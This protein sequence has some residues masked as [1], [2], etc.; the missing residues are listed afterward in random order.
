[1]SIYVNLRDS[2]YDSLNV[3]FPTTQIVQAYNNGPEVV[4]PYVTFDVVD[5]DQI[6]EEYLSSFADEE[7]MQQIVSQYEVKVRI[8]F[9]GKQDSSFDAAAL[10]N[11]F[12]FVIDQTPT[13]HAF[14]L[15][16]LSYLRKDSVKRIPRKRE[17]DWYINYQIDL[18]FGYQVEARQSIDI[19]ESVNIEADYDYES[20]DSFIHTIQIP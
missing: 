12:Y 19:I 11:D 3:I 20:H 4:T 6:G 10:A 15:N 9:V 1:M 2:I 7:G 18:I 14:L 13:Q 16:N 17:T 8:E 5:I